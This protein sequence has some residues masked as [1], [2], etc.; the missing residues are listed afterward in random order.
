MTPRAFCRQ[1]EQEI[2][3]GS[4]HATTAGLMTVMAIYNLAAVCFRRERHL[5]AN[6]VLYTT[7]AVLEAKKTISH[8]S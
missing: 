7:L 2:L 5:A 8:W 6:A 1:G 3:K 4:F